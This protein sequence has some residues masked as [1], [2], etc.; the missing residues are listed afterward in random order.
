MAYYASHRKQES[1]HNKERYYCK[2]E[3]KPV[4]RRVRKSKVNVYSSITP[5]WK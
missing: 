4:P 2:K 1:D 3:G 5:W